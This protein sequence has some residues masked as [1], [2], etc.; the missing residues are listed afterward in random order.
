MILAPSSG[1][2]E[3][4]IS[5]VS[6][7]VLDDGDLD[8]KAVQLKRLAAYERDCYRRALQ[9]LEELGTGEKIMKGL[10]AYCN[11]A[12]L[13]GEIHA[14]EDISPKLVRCC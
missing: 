14:V 9:K 8:I 4:I 10:K 1:I 3:N 5:T 7:A 6:I 12:D 13:Y 2:E 11:V